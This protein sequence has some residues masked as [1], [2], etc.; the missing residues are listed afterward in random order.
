MEDLV[1]RLAQYNAFK[2]LSALLCTLNTASICL[3]T[4]APS[5][6]PVIADASRGSESNILILVNEEYKNKTPERIK[7][8]WWNVYLLGPTQKL[9]SIPGKIK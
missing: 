7:S 2:L 9:Y 1:P 5:L 4:S 8:G 6:A 3:H